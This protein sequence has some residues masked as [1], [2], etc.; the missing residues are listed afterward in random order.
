[1]RPIS[2]CSHESVHLCVTTES[3]VESE[4]SSELL[5]CPA[6]IATGA[7]AVVSFRC[8]ALTGPI[9]GHTASPPCCLLFKAGFQDI[10]D[11]TTAYVQQQTSHK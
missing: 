6:S 7:W 9:P 4:R 3:G 11:V 10:D 8:S 5:P 1:M 2:P